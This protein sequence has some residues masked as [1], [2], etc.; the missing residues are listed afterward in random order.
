MVSLVCSPSPKLEALRASVI[1][2]MTTVPRERT[3]DPTKRVPTHPKPVVGQ[4]PQRA[5]PLLIVPLEESPGKIPVQV[6]TVSS[7]PLSAR[8]ASPLPKVVGSIPQLTC[9][10]RGNS[11]NSDNT[12][13]H[14][15]IAGSQN[16]LSVPTRTVSHVA[17][18]RMPG[19]KMTQT[20]TSVPAQQLAALKRVFPD[21]PEV[22]WAKCPQKEFYSSSLLAK[23]VNKQDRTTVLIR[24]LTE[25]VEAQ[26]KEM[27]SLKKLLYKYVLDYNLPPPPVI[28][29]RLIEVLAQTS[30]FPEQ[31]KMTDSDS[32][33]DSQILQNLQKLNAEE[34]PQSPPTPPPTSSIKNPA[35]KKSNTLKKKK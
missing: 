1:N 32:D 34:G 22:H 13:D 17:A 16:L 14:T 4:L 30:T 12:G 35:P 20:R 3:P 27:K 19:G 6:E 10:P 11:K 2:T 23:L 26:A 21:I 25:L 8:K 31:D 9:P 5:V 29:P 28:Q 18:R 15:L 7:S 33:Q 24:T